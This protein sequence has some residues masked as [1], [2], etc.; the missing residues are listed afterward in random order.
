VADEGTIYRMSPAGAL[1]TLVEFNQSGG[2][3]RGSTP[4][5]ELAIGND[6]SFYGSTLAGGVLG[7]GTIFKV[8]PFGSIQTLVE[9]QGSDTPRGEAPNG[10]CRAVDGNFYGT[11]Y[12]G[13][14]FNVG[15]VFKVTPAGALTT[16]FD[17]PSSG[18]GF[19]PRGRL[20]QGSDNNFYGVTEFGGQGNFGTVFRITP[21]GVL[22]TLVEFTGTDSFN[23]HTNPGARPQSGLVRATDGNFYGT[24][25]GGGH[26]ERGTLF[27]VTPAGALTTLIE[28]AGIA[29][30]ARGGEPY[31]Q[32]I[33]ASDGN[34]YV[35]TV[36]GATGGGGTVYRVRFGPKPV[37]QSASAITATGATL[38]GL[39]NP[40]GNS[41]AVTFEL[42]TSPNLTGAMTISAGGLGA[43]SADQPVAVGANGLSANTTYYFRVTAQNGEN[44]NR[45]LGEILRFVTTTSAQ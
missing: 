30:T 18:G 36:N 20:V 31:G 12:R 13:G 39:V 45:Q 41:T 7:A 38:H 29:S 19:L 33:Q 32:M 27:K 1:T 25:L 24:T 44:P 2:T 26:F 3:L 4:A 6:G 42:S 8:T 28:F 35:T 11:T 37:S 43:G 22:T 17:F 34:L 9:F 15:T 40:N 16:F 21:G 23:G 5:G 10:L 14:N